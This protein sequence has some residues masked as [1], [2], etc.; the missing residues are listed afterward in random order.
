MVKTQDFQNNFTDD[1]TYTDEHGYNFLSNSNLYGGELILS[2]V[3]SVGKV[4]IVPH[5]KLKM[6]L[7]PNTIMVRFFDEKVNLYLYYLMQ[8]KFGYTCLKN[9][10]SA[11]A[12]QKFNKTDFKNI[13]IP[14]PP[15]NEQLKIIE[16]LKN[17]STMINEINDLNAQIQSL[18]SQIKNKIINLG[19]HGKL[20]NSDDNYYYE[21][22]LEKYKLGEV[23][24][25][26]Q[27][28]KYIVKSEKYSENYQIPVLTPGKSFI[29]GKTNETDGIY[30]ASL[31]PVII[32]DDFTTSHRYVDF[33]FKV[34]SSA[35]KI[36]K[37]KNV[38][39]YDIK[40]L[41]YLLSSISIN[42]TTHKR[43]WISTFSE[44]CIQIP[45]VNIQKKI[46]NRI[47]YFFNKLGLNY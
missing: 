41:S 43:Y 45:N 44:I 37:S 15:K 16:Y 9:I 28:T 42:V 10:T 31:E 3:G 26:E 1:L 24:I 11:T 5:L 46:V 14:V 32:F 20:L 21:K 34:K 25:Y 17:I 39:A 23:L 19:I 18:K 7:A 38:D 35:M 27:P 33:D 6:T 4:Y 47:E 30:K 13:L 2:N 8:S 29:L 36:L 12:I 22:S 40:F